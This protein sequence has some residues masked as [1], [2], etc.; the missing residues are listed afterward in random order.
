MVVVADDLAGGVT[1]ERLVVGALGDGRAVPRNRRAERRADAARRRWPATSPF[2]GLHLAGKLPVVLNW[3]TGPANLAHAVEARRASPTSSRRRRSST[4]CTS[5]CRARSMLFLEDLRGQHRQARAAP[6]AARG[7]LVRRRG[8]RIALLKPLSSDPHKPAVVLFTSG[9]EK[10]PKAVPLTH[11]NI[12]SDQRGCVE[13]LQ[14]T[15]RQLRARLPADVPQL[16]PDRDRAAAAVRRRARRPPP[17]P[18]RRRRARPQDRRVQADAHRRHA[19][20]P[21]ATSSTARSRATWTR[22]GSSSSARRSAPQLAL[23]QGEANS[24]RT[25]RCWRATASPSARRWCRSTGPGTSKPGTVGEPLPGVEVCVTDLET[26]DVLPPGQMG[27]LHVAGRRCS[28][29]TSGHDGPPPFGEIGGKRWY[30]TGDLGRARRGR[31]R[32]SSTAG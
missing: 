23:R 15:P 29:A 4:A 26:K 7:A 22:C 2:L 10:A 20:V 8:S 13:A 3:T 17:R 11:A 1:Y 6:P 9:S 25:R 27:M 19:D 30:V 16:R 21:A 24:P 31:A 28:P 32:S 18:D 14:V 12:I 5:R